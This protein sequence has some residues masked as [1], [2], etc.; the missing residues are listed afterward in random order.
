MRVKT[1]SDFALTWRVEWSQSSEDYQLP[2]TSY[3]SS[4]FDFIK[5]LVLNGEW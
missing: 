2:V 3:Q 4:A 1:L 5:P